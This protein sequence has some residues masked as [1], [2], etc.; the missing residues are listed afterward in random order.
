MTDWE[1]SVIKQKTSW[2]LMVDYASEQAPKANDSYAYYWSFDANFVVHK[3]AWILEIENW[4]WKESGKMIIKGK[5]SVVT[6]A[7]ERQITTK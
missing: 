3:F 2:F 5:T 4:E 1:E 7:S 6:S